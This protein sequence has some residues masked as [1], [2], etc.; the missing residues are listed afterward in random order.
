LSAKLL[1]LIS[2]LIFNEGFLSQE[3]NILVG[4]NIKLPD[5]KVIKNYQRQWIWGKYVS[6]FVD[7]HIF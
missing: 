4:V 5:V 3:S 6:T 2:A 7:G 1:T